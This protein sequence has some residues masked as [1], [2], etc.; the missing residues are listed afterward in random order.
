MSRLAN[1]EKHVLG[2]IQKLEYDKALL[3]IEA[4]LERC[5]GY[6][7][8]KDEEQCTLYELRAMVYNN[9][10]ESEAALGEAWLAFKTHRKYRSFFKYSEVANI[11]GE[12]ILGQEEFGR[13]ISFFEDAVEHA[14]KDNWK[15][16]FNSHLCVLYEA[17]KEYTK[18]KCKSAKKKAGPVQ[19][20]VLK[21][22]KPR[23]K[24]LLDSMQRDLGSKQK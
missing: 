16:K 23:L 24:F 2:Q 10:E 20:T 9:K 13:A 21:K 17:R 12:Y 5:T 8:E 22:L 14:S 3:F 19:D 7:R 11:I 1:I 4:C 15:E 18:S 6:S